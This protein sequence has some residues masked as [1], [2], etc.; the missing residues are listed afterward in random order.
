[1]AQLG[2]VV[3]DPDIPEAV[4]HVFEWFMELSRARG[5]NGFGSNP[6]SHMEIAAW[7]ALYGIQPLPREL[8][9]IAAMDAAFLSEM[10]KQSA[11]ETI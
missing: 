11:K 2:R 6:I 3:E 10:A 4:E 9:M 8:R 5:S 1:M 7:S